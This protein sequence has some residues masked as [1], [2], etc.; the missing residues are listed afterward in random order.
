MS[1]GCISYAKGCLHGLVQAAHALGFKV[2][3]VCK[4]QFVALTASAAHAQ[5]TCLRLSFAFLE[6]S[7]SLEDLAGHL[8]V[9][10]VL[11]LSKLSS[12]M[13]LGVFDLLAEL[14]NVLCRLSILHNLTHRLRSLDI[15]KVSLISLRIFS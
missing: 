13:L 4:T 9:K 10:L 3:S 7:F 5:L 6:G 2:G 1:L 12:E 8:L 11:V 15:D 14:L